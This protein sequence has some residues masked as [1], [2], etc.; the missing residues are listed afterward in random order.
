M[1]LTKVK[2]VFDACTSA[3]YVLSLKA[4]TECT[5][6]LSKNNEVRASDLVVVCLTYV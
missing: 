6:L 5:S 2:A 3:V 4:S 1:P